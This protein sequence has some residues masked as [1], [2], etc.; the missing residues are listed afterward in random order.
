MTDLP[1]QI[2]AVLRK[3]RNVLIACHVAPDG[4]CLG[5]ALGLRLALARIGVDAQVGSADGVPDAFLRLPGAA[6]VIS[7]PP[8]AHAEVAVAVECSTP[9]R[10]G[11]FAQALAGVPEPINSGHPPSKTPTR[12]PPLSGTEGAGG[13]GGTG[14][15]TDPG[16]GT[17]P[18]PNP[19]SP[20]PPP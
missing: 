17:P 8:T 19:R 9:E 14:P 6:G 5:S 13:R 15:R 2:A 16:G 10:A 4:D 18:P 7:A 3:S 11:I 20:A 12:R 1:Y